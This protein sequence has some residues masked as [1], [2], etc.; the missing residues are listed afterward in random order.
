MLRR[1]VHYTSRDQCASG[2]WPLIYIMISRHSA[3]HV[4]NFAHARI[5]QHTLPN[6]GDGERKLRIITAL[7]PRRASWWSRRITGV[8]TRPRFRWLKHILPAPPNRVRVISRHIVFLQKSCTNSR[9]RS[10]TFM[11]Q[12][13]PQRKNAAGFSRLLEPRTATRAVMGLPIVK[14]PRYIETRIFGDRNCRS[15]AT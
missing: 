15:L 8:L 9:Y 12:Q 3:G 7:F 10:E 13:L 6:G 14:K 2:Q 1:R 4:Q 5:V 11:R